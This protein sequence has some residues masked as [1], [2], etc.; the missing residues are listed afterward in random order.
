MV[1]NA[2]QPQ[3]GIWNWIS[4][5]YPNHGQVLDFFHASEKL[6]EFAREAFKNKKERN[7][8]INHQ[9]ELLRD[10]GVEIVMVNVELIKCKG[11]ALERQAALLSYYNNNMQRMQYK[12]YKEKGWSIGSG[13][14]ESAH[15]TVIQQRMKLSGQRW[16]QQGAQY[17]V[18]LR[19]AEKSGEWDEVKE[20][21]CNP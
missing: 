17:I 12:D 19:A 15:R 18:N 20:L 3:A 1:R 16:T 9:I 7:K 11:R 4:D 14:M 5:F 10:N 8:W 21:I 2:C 6:H 13:P